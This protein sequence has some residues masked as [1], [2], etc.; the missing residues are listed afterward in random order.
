MLRVVWEMLSAFSRLIK[1]WLVFN[2]MLLV[3]MGCLW[4]L[5][6]VHEVI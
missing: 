2:S 1:V 6:W 5:A 4:K 3:F